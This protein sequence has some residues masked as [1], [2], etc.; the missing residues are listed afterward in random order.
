MVSTEIEKLEKKIQKQEEKIKAIEEKM[1]P[2]Q[3]RIKNLENYAIANHHKWSREKIFEESQKLT[4]ICIEL[5]DLEDAC[6]PHIKNIGG[7]KVKIKRYK[8]S[9]TQANLFTD[10]QRAYVISYYSNPNNKTLA[11]ASRR[12]GKSKRTITEFA[13]E[14]RKELGEDRV[15]KLG[16]AKR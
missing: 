8:K 13:C 5:A 4:D 2:L 14:L 11:K 12:L 10:E 6:K 3:R 9:E 1:K 16:K 7:Y 15:P